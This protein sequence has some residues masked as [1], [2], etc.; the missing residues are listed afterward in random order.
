[1]TKEMRSFESGATRSSEE[2]K[3]DY[4]GFL[5]PRVLERYAQYMNENRVQTDG[6]LRDSDNWQKGMGLNVYMK[7]IF[8]HFM[9]LWKLHRK[10]K[11]TDTIEVAL[12]AL[13]FNVMGYMHEHLVGKEAKKCPIG[14][15][16]PPEFYFKR[17]A[18][19]GPNGTEPY[20]VVP[21][22][23]EWHLPHGVSESSITQNLKAGSRED[24]PRAPKCPS[25]HPITA[26]DPLGTGEGGLTP[27][28]VCDCLTAGMGGPCKCAE[29]K[30]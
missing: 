10:V 29:V 28:F 18:P 4:E 6:A 16:L 20:K 7:S 17:Y 23:M 19:L 13:L 3:Y 1:M 2:G 25:K 14:E 5:S 21:E 15:P 22:D 27:V 8:R 12:C 9:S 11:D 24:F 26:F 30:S